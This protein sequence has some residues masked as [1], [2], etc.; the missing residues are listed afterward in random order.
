MKTGILSLIFALFFALSL[1][2]S[3]QTTPV[4]H[5]K[6][7]TQHI[8]SGPLQQEEPKPDESTPPSP[9]HEEIPVAEVFLEDCHSFDDFSAKKPPT[10]GRWV[11]DAMDESYL[12]SYL[13]DFGEDGEITLLYEFRYP[14]LLLDTEN[15]AEFNRKLLTSFFTAPESEAHSQKEIRDYLSSAPKHWEDS[16]ETPT[17]KIVD[18]LAFEDEEEGLVAIVLQ[19]EYCFLFS[20]VVGKQDFYYYDV[21]GDR[22]LTQSEY[23][24][25]FDIDAAAM[26]QM[27]SQTPILADSAQSFSADGVYPFIPVGDDRYLTFPEANGYT[28]TP[29]TF[30]QK[31]GKIAKTVL[32]SREHPELC[33]LLTKTWIDR[34]SGGAF[35]LSLVGDKVVVNLPAFPRTD[36]KSWGLGEELLAVTDRGELICMASEEIYQNGEA[37]SPLYIVPLA[38]DPQFV[39][40]VMGREYYHTRIAY[41]LT[42]RLPDS[43]EAYED[44]TEMFLDDGADRRQLNLVGH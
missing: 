23:Q 30:V 12:I 19:T 42:P 24:K 14:K 13:H 44:L 41:K 25:R 40:H 16:F 22:E 29:L 7:P 43:P 31:D 10:R 8:P 4:V 6:P 15:A 36:N 17:P 27:L 39:D 38:K 35:T 18:Y 26:T 20:E 21:K 5:D 9:S 33:E 34:E 1:L 3:C 28:P 2:T 32:K 37:L 11:D